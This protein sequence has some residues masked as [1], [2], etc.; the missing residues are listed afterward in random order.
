M[1]SILK[2]SETFLHKRVDRCGALSCCAIAECGIICLSRMVKYM[3]R[4]IPSLSRLMIR[5]CS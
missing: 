3:Y 2:S 5:F 1:V 4:C